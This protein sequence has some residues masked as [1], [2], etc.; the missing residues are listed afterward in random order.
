MIIRIYKII[1]RRMIILELYQKYKNK[2]Q[3]KLYRQHYCRA[4]YLIA[5]IEAFKMQLI[6]T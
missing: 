1:L 6:E 3:E 5:N 4:K 2:W